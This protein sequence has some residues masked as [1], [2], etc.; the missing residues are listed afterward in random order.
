MI[1]D[2]DLKAETLVGYVDTT[3]IDQAVVD[4]LR[5]S[6]GLFTSSYLKAVDQVCRR[7]S[8]ATATIPNYYVDG[9]RTFDTR[10]AAVDRSAGRFLADFRAVKAPKRW[11]AFRAASVADMAVVS[12]ALGQISSTLTPTS[13]PAVMNAAQ[14]RYTGATSAARKRANRR[15]DAQGLFRCGSGY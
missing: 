12:T 7:H 14:K 15:F 1:A 9:A 2:R 3:T 5:N 8:N 4:A 6:D 10:V 11:K 13:S